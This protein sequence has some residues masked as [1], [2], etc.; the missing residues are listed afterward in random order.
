MMGKSN[1]ILDFFKRKNA[2]SSNAQNSNVNVGDT[3]SST[4]D[5]PS[6]K[7]SPKRLWRV[8]INEFDINSLEFD[9]RLRHQI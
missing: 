4:S 5:I 9:P 6:S 7:N 8:D 3:S 2:Q 1:T